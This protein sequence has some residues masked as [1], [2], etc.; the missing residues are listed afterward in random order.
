WLTMRGG[1][2]DWNRMELLRGAIAITVLAAED[3]LLP[4]APITDDSLPAAEAKGFSMPE[5]P[6]S[7]KVEKLSIGQA[8]IGAPLL[9]QE[10]IVTLSGSAILEGGEGTATINAQ[11]IDESL[12]RL[13]LEG[14][15]ANA[16]GRLSLDTELT[17]GPDGI[18][19]TM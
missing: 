19:A 1:T 5:L 3:I 18:A 4:H 2:L 6:V 15:Y 14:S 16:T 9:G 17:E 12:G 7:V 13:R 10:A 8:V 11:R